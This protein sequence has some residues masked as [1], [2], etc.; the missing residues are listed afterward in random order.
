[1]IAGVD[2]P[3]FR[4]DLFA[5]TAAYY[6]R[7]RLPYPD[8]LLDSVRVRVPITG[9]GRLLDLACGTGQIAFALAA[10]FVEVWAVDQEAEAI[11]FAAAK[12]ERL[13]ARHVHCLTARAE[14]LALEPPFELVAIG[15]A[16]HR[17]Q[18]SVVAEVA[19]SLLRPGGGLALLWSSTPWQGEQPWQQVM[20]DTLERWRR[21]ADAMDR[22]PPGWDDAIAADP[23]EAVLTRAGFS[24]A[25]SAEFTVPHTWTTDELVGWVYSTSFLN[26]SALGPHAAAFDH[27]L[28][29]QL[30]T[31]AP[32]GSFP[33]DVRFAYDL[34]TRPD[35]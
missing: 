30:L 23:H 31:C 34:A 11:D 10:D 24:Y 33:A 29:T 13:G 27:D 25:G 5:G 1:M 26:K 14:D 17:L 2:E 18:R 12:A 21:T 19:M 6:D 28:R 9:Q 4:P 16:F 8:V 3:R 7:F 22:I 15:N 20:W 35:R 32:H